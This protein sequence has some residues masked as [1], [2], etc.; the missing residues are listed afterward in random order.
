M[1]FRL[2]TQS[3]DMAARRNQKLNKEQSFGD[4]EKVYDF[5]EK[6]SLKLNKDIVCIANVENDKSIELPVH[7]LIL[8]LR[9]TEEILTALRKRQGG[10][11][12]NYQQHIGGGWHVSVNTGFACVDIR[13]FYLP[14]FGLEPKPTKEGIA[15]R[16]REWIAFVRAL[17]RLFAD[18]EP[19]RQVVPCCDNH[20]SETVMLCNECCP[21][22]EDMYDSAT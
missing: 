7:R 17:R 4:V 21:Y 16:L 10:E 20:D 12:V 13:R 9:C 18:N 15:I 11:H 5:G 19:L 2:V 8:L 6:R 1:R 14:L 3:I 22:R